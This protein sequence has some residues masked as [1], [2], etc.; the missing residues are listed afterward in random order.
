ML[1]LPPC[2]Y[3]WGLQRLAE[4]FCRSGSY[5]QAH[6]FVLAATGVSIGKRQ[7]EQIA[8]GA[9]ADV[10][11]FYDAGGP[12]GQEQ[13]DGGQPGQPDGDAVLPLALSADGKG[14]AMLPESR[15]ARTKAPDQ[16][17]KNFGSLP[18]TG[19][20][21][22]KR[23]AEVACVF[24]VIPQLRTPEQVMASHHGGGDG[25]TGRKADKPAPKAVNRRYQVDIAA[26]RSAAISW[27]FDE[28]AH[29]DPGHARD[30]IALVDG[31]N[32]Q[33]TP[34]EAE[35]AERGVTGHV[36]SST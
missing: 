31:N 27:L 36:S 1:N 20:K 18:G 10:A 26:D 12:A 28:A 22:H 21:G 8:A 4:M 6:E 5:E 23:I 17:V 34:I 13:P 9:A 35:A 15:R 2:G 32:P 19:E 33:I 30:W 3:S 16:R 14:V 11:A 24:D 7:L 29:R 25:G